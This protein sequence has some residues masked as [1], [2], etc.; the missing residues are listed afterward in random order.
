[1]HVSNTVIFPRFGC[2]K[3]MMKI[4]ERKKY[5]LHHKV[6][7]PLLELPIDMI[8]DFVVGDALHGYTGI[9]VRLSSVLRKKTRD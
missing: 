3:E 4:F 7:S 2:P 9:Q 8:D 6:D 1:M 5:G